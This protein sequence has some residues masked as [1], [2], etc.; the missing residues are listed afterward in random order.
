M[1][2]RKSNRNLFLATAIPLLIG[3]TIYFSC[4]PSTLVYYSWI[5]FKEKIDLNSIHFSAYE[6]CLSFV[7]NSFSGNVAIYSLPGAL[8]AFSLTYYIKKRYLQKRFKRHS[9]FRRLYKYSFFAVVISFLTEI[10]QLIGLAPGEYDQTDVLTALAAA[11][12]ALML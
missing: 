12:V 9:Y 11:A 2:E 5:P 8:Y 1:S 10:L 3:F 7:N 6:K 4:R